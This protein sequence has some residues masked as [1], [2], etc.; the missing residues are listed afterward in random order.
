MT[1]V[2][3]CSNLCVL[4][5]EQWLSEFRNANGREATRCSIERSDEPWFLSLDD[6][7]IA[8]PDDA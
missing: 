7:L 1:M 3:K 2:L 8:V 6:Y 5:K 4:E